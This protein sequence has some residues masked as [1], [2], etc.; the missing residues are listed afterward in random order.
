M[1]V[2]MRHVTVL[3]TEKSKEEV[4]SS[5][6]S[7]GLVHITYDMS[8]PLQ[9]PSLSNA[10]SK[11]VI[12]ERA[13]NIV[14]SLP[15][16][17]KED[18]VA[19]PE[20]VVAV[21]D[22]VARLDDEILSLS[23]EVATY[24]P[25]GNFDVASLETYRDAG[26]PVVLF[27]GSMDFELPESNDGGIVKILHTD[28]RE[29]RVYG[30]TVGDMT[31]PHQ[32]E[33]I[34]PPSRTLEELK[35]LLAEKKIER[36]EDKRKLALFAAAVKSLKKAIDE[37]RSLYIFSK[38]AASMGEDGGIAWLTGYCPYDSEDKLTEAAG[39]GG[40]AVF[41]RDPLPDEQPPTLLR[42]PKAFKPITAL[43]DMLGIAPGYY[44]ADISIVFY[45]FFTIF[46]AML[47]GDAGY[48]TIILIMT[49][50]ARL[51][52]RKVSR[53]PF[54]LLGIFS[55]ATIIW[56]VM[57]ATYFGMPASVL[58]VWLKPHTANWFADQS[59]VM[60]LCFVLGAIHLSLARLWN[61]AC[62]FPD[63]KFLAEAG[64]I[65]IIWTMYYASCMVVVE[66]AVFPTFM[67]YVTIVSVVLLALFM[68]KK[69]E[70]KTEGINLVIL[71]LNI[72]SCLGDIIS[73]VRLFAVGL[74]SVK[75]AENF[76]AMALDLQ[77]PLAVK[78]PAVIIILLIG[79][80]L[81]FAMGTLSILV[82]A[83]RLNTLEFSNHKGISW[84]GFAYEP[85]RK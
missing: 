33:I 4:L 77:L 3:C 56:G 6:R 63:T 72:V 12:A 23:K 68:L 75:V 46:F 10:D 28:Y 65:G 70:L 57:T 27:S 7:L 36:D 14:R 47:V 59:N 52:F 83:V 26:L 2:K 85:F 80:G 11:Y 50:F 41:T 30:V 58:P 34:P 74:A 79:H 16:S 49:I 20:D 32:C 64:W 55:A 67:I 42:P 1:I 84:S 66:G 69:S 61:A 9:S 17:D 13:L 15:K 54:I 44:E 73:Y 82:H 37:R 19:T 48:G 18:L 81:N 5:L 31:I 40:W 45:G 29:K 39:E 21:A 24:G 78:I 53:T 62:L 43:F 25:F 38:A 76:N 22:K 8:Q 51:K 35:L 60:Q 71:P